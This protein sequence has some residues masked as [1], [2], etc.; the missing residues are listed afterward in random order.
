MWTDVLT[1]PLQ[2]KEFRKTRAQLMNCAMKYKDKEEY[3]TN[4]RKTLI[5]QTS[6]Q[7]AIQT[8]QE[9]VGRYLTIKKGTR[10]LANKRIMRGIDR[11]RTVIRTQ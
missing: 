11:R 1:K 10:K 5:D 7:D 3:T 8:V 6:Q 9:C 4:K 2:G